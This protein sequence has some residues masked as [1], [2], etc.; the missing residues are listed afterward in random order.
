VLAVEIAHGKEARVARVVL[1][2]LCCVL[3]SGRAAIAPLS[4]LVSAPLGPAPAQMYEQTLVQL[5]K[6]NFVLVKTNVLGRSRGFALLGLVTIYPAT[7]TKAM[8]RL[9]SD[10]EMNIGHSQTITHLIVEKSNTYYILFGIPEVD[11]RADIVEF[12]PKS[13]SPKQ[14]DP[15]PPDG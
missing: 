15:K 14:P 3:L 5:D 11:V 2:F 6:D 9:Y 12:R 1:F 7:L 8:G 13:G 10:A 4:S